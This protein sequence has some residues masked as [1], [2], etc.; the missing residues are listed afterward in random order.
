ML[1]VNAYSISKRAYNPIHLNFKTTDFRGFFFIHKY[2]TL[3][4]FTMSDENFINIFKS[5][6]PELKRH[7]DMTTL[8]HWGKKISESKNILNKYG[9]KY[10]S[11][12]DED[13]ILL[14]I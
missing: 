10:F 13:G 7:L 4:F 12:N 6:Y 3:Y 1:E 11:Q 5:M 14:E 2:N 9:K 8:R